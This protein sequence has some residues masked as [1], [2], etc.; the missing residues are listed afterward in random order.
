M[1]LK[2][3]KNNIDICGIAGSVESSKGTVDLEITARYPT[4]FRAKVTAVVLGK[5]TTLLR[6]NEFDK[7]IIN[8]HRINDLILKLADPKLSDPNFNKCSKIDMI[9]GA[10]IYSEIIMNGIIKADDN[11]FVAQETEVGFEKDPSLRSLYVYG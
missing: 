11:S 6:N 4:S 1:N 10:D 5:L 7:R 2:Q 8:D 9:L 3:T